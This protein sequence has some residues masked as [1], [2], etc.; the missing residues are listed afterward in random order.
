MKASSITGHEKSFEQTGLDA[1][2]KKF[3]FQPATVALAGDPQGPLQLVDCLRQNKD[4]SFYFKDVIAKKRIVL[5][6]TIGYLKGDIATLTQPGELVS[7]PFVIA[8]NG[9][10]YNLWASKYWSY[11]LG[12]GAVGGNTLMSQTSIGIELS[13]IGPLKKIGPNLVTTYSDTDV[14]CTLED[15]ALYTELPQLYRG[16][17]YFATFPE[18][19]YKSLITL[20]QFL[21]KKY[22][23]PRQFIEEASRYSSFK[24]PELAVA[25]RGII[26]HVN[27]RP[28]GKVDIGPAFDWERVIREVKA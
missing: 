24:S 9:T 17:R 5:H 11:H 2:G 4:S 16:Y 26:S 3:I 8:R 22:A 1:H 21:T 14:Y 19:Q 23:I 18:A 13:N 15:T 10:I 25:S 28:T 7:V 20:L 6:F 27:V 12:P